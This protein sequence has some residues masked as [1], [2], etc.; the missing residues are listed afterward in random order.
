[1]FN[2]QCWDSFAL[3]TTTQM[4]ALLTCILAIVV[5]C[6]FAQNGS[7]SGKLVDGKTGEELIGAIIQVEGKNV[8]A[9][10]DFLGEFRIENLPAGTYTLDC[11]MV[12]YQP[13]RIQ[14]IVVTEGKVTSINITL[15]EQALQGAFVEIV[16]YKTTHSEA[17]VL[18][19]MRDTKGVMSGVSSALIQKSQDRNASEVARRIPGVTVVDNRFVLVRGLTERYNSVMLNGILAPSLESDVRS[20]SFDVIPSQV[21]DRFLI[22]KSPSPDRPGEFA[23]GVINVITKS[24]PDARTTLD[25]S[26][27][28]GYRS[29]TTGNPFRTNVNSSSEWLGRDG[30]TR[31]LPS[32]FPT[33]VR[34][35]SD[36]AAIADLGRSLPNSWGFTE[37][38]ASPDSRV[39][40]TI[41]KRFKIGNAEIGNFT[42]IQYSNTSVLQRSQRMDYN[43]YDF[44]MQT[45]DTV[46]AFND[47]IHQKAA[48][49]GVLHNWGVRTKNHVIE[50]KNFV[51]QNGMQSN[52]F[53]S[54]RHIEE[55]AWRREYA[56]R[57]TERT[58]FTTQLTGSHELFSKRGTA[59]WSAG[60]GSTRRSDPDWRRIR[61]TKPFDGSN[62]D[63]IAYI[64]FSAQPFFLGRLFMNLTEDIRTATA[65]YEHKLFRTESTKEEDSWVTFKAGIYLEDRDRRFGSRN[66]GYAPVSF[67]NFDWSIMEQPVDQILA[68][69][70]I[71]STGLRL[72]EDTRAADTYHASSNLLAWYGMVTMPIERW[73]VTGGV[74]FEQNRQHMSSADI[75]GVPLE[76]KLDSLMILPSVNI[77]Y[78]LNKKMLLR[79]AYGKTVNRPEFREL[80]PFTF[81][82]FENNFIN[83]GNP[84][85]TFAVIENYD[86]RWEHYP[87]AGEFISIA[88][89]YKYFR[90]PIE[91]YFVPG[92]GSGGT[93][94]FM[95]G[96][97]LSA[98]SLGAEVDIRKSLRNLTRVSFIN[99]LSVVANASVIKSNITLSAQGVET[100]LNDSRPMVGQSPYIINAGLY[101]ENDSL[102][103][104][105]AALYNIIGQRV[106]IV[107]IPDF[108][109]VYEMP[110][111]LIDLSVTKSFR[112]GFS[113]R[114]GVQDM[115]NMDFMFVQDA[116]AD[117]VL[118]RTADQ[119]I[120]SFNRGAYWTMSLQYRFRE[121]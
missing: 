72:D 119:R 82:D 96:N 121:K 18:M 80:A 15:D 51:N 75:T 111:S 116:N 49:L 101:Y 35:V 118:S 14:G 34:N 112:N 113:V 100:G 63:Y 94:S 78:H 84:K 19:E 9:A 73:T 1:M 71:G 7:L 67:M 108:P 50:W 4:K 17:S 56:Y 10:S 38:N 24:F 37:Q 110:R 68:P 21:I 53:R 30:G 46:F 105:V 95:P 36:P 26:M 48:N 6:S 83:S 28:I 66:L 104:Q 62:P 40:A 11:R 23:G 81:Y 107:G 93:R 69:E 47:D 32:A 74:R 97:A 61:Y 3:T 64:P 117:G 115:L 65:N 92:V 54:G 109:E 16:E 114:V 87:S 59:S 41:G 5:I 31:G 57:Y 89:F 55:G 91:Q 120:Q 88:G 79:A 103:L 42:T 90:N 2:G 44:T 25:V 43:V 86:L 102:G 20:F 8:G 29:G 22:Y 70:N 45:S 99:N 58:L 52:T 106:I 13:K 76:A 77:S 60:Y 85:L 98:N 39:N 27:G 33:N 12:S